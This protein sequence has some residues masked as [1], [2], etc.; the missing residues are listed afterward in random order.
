LVSIDGLLNNAEINYS[1][2]SVKRPSQFKL[3]SDSDLRDELR[4]LQTAGADEIA[5]KTVSDSLTMLASETTVTEKKIEI[6]SLY[7]PMRYKTDQQ[8]TNLVIV[9]GAFTKAD[10]VRSARASNELDR[11]IHQYGNTWFLQASYETL[12]V[13]LDNAMQPYL[14]QLNNEPVL[15]P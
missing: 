15:M 12:K 13:M 1:N 4:Q 2:I 14:E 8:K 6:L 9:G 5:V 10:L 3:K 7:D 11:I